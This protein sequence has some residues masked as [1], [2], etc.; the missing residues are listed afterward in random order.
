[1]LAIANILIYLLANAQQQKMVVN[2]SAVWSSY[3]L[4]Q[5]GFLSV[6]HARALCYLPMIAAHICGAHRVEEQIDAFM[7]YCIARLGGLPFLAAGSSIIFAST[8]ATTIVFLRN[9]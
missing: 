7:G 5:V 4:I 3:L 9:G 2:L 6:F 1:M 8:V